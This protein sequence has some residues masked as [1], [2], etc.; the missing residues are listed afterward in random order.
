MCDSTYVEVF[1]GFIIPN[2]WTNV[3]WFYNNDFTK[4]NN[5]YPDY[6]VN[7]YHLLNEYKYGKPSTTALLADGVS[8]SQ[9]TTKRSNDWNN[10]DWQKLQTWHRCGKKGNIRPNWKNIKSD[11]DNYDESSNKEKKKVHKK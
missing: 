4:G 6:M 10:D 8:F 1:Y 7:V 2:T 5:K 3:G 11:K 9:K